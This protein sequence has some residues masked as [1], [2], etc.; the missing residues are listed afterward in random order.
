MRRRVRIAT[1]APKCRVTI[2]HR[3][4]NAWLRCRF[5]DLSWQ[6]CHDNRQPTTDNQ[7]S[8]MIHK[9]L[10]LLFALSLFGLATHAQE[11][12]SDTET[13]ETETTNNEEARKEAEF[14]DEEKADRDAR[15]EEHL[16]DVL[17]TLGG[18]PAAQQTG[19]Q[20]TQSNAPQGNRPL[21]GRAGKFKKADRA[22]VKRKFRRK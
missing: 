11:T 1:G 14:S 7:P 21:A 15:A 6:S 19:Q 3:L 9:S 8:N 4:W 12:T 5:V 22:L 20:A 10:I 13:T 16:D 2:F 18:G 17:S